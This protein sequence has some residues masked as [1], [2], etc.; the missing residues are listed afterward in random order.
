MKQSDS[1]RDIMPAEQSLPAVSVHQAHEPEIQQERMRR[2]HN[3]RA[4]QR[5]A[6]HHRINGV[7]L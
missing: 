1:H 4:S 6:R 3:A 5:A 2:L 7:A